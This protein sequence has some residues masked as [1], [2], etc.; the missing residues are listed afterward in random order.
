MHQSNALLKELYSSL[1]LKTGNVVLKREWSA[2]PVHEDELSFLS[3]RPVKR[4][5]PD[6]DSEVIDLTSS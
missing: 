2:S 1:K 6:D 3:E 4:T 5:R